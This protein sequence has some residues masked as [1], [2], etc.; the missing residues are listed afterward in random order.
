[1]KIKRIK[2]KEMV[3]AGVGSVLPANPARVDVVMSFH[4]YGVLI[5]NTKT[6]ETILTPFHNI[7]EIVVEDDK[8]ISK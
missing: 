3:S 4:K 2:I 1:M 5:H 7:V 6:K 8:P